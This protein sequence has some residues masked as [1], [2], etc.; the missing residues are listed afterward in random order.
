[1]K[2]RQELMIDVLEWMGRLCSIPPEEAVEL[3]S[4]IDV[5]SLAREYMDDCFYESEFF[6]EQPSMSEVVEVFT[7]LIDEQKR[8]ENV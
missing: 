3:L 7:R 2:K 6:T 1:M 5:E 4:N 8:R